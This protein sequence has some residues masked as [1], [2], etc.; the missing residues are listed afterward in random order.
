[1]ISVYI[2]PLQLTVAILAVKIGMAVRIFS[3]LER[4]TVRIFQLP[5]L[6]HSVEHVLLD[7]LE[8][9][10]NALVKLCYGN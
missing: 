4:L 9:E 1:M 2:I 3:V 5:V 8:M 10:R 6:E 7:L